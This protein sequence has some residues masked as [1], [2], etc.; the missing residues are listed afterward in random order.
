MPT[1]NPVNAIDPNGLCAIRQFALG[2]FERQSTGHGVVD[3][4]QLDRP[5][6]PRSTFSFFANVYHGKWGW[7]AMNLAAVLPVVGVLKYADE[8]AE[9]TDVAKK[10]KRGYH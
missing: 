2:D 9:V 8:V 7:A 4:L 6:C 5:G 1:P 3:W 10:L